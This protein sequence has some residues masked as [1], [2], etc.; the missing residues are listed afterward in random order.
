MDRGQP[1]EREVVLAAIAG[2]LD[3]ARAG[4]GGVL[5]VVGE[6]GLGK[7]TCLDQAAV[8]A[9]P[10]VQVGLGRGDVMEVSLPF[11]VFTAALGALGYHDLLTVL[12]SGAGLGDVRAA[13]FYAVLRWLE[14]TSGPVLLA[15]DDLHWADPDSLALLSFLCRRLARLPVAVLGTMRPWPQGAH[16]LS[17]ALVYDGYASVLGPVSPCR[18]HGGG[19]SRRVAG[20]GGAGSVVR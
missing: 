20:R 6:A 16:E 14:D 19:R 17:S 12:A 7:T 11:G 18:G 2:L 3:G 9:D 5:F 13:R 10:E 8:L 1:L 4:R 15:L